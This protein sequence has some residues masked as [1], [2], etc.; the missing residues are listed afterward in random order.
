[1]RFKYKLTKLTKLTKSTKLKKLTL[2]LMLSTAIFTNFHNISF[3]QN[4]P[5]VSKNSSISNYKKIVEIDNIIAIVGNEVITQNELNKSYQQWEQNLVKNGIELPSKENLQKQLLERLILYKAQ[6]QKARELGISISEPEL[7]NSLN[8]I[9]A[10]NNMSLEEFRDFV[11]KNG[12]NFNSFQE[13]IRNEIIINKLRDAEIDSRINI[14]EAEIDNYLKHSKNNNQFLAN[15]SPVNEEIYN[16]QYLISHIIIRVPENA[17]PEVIE[18]YHNKAIDIQQKALQGQNFNRLAVAFSDAQ[19]ALSGGNLGW[20]NINELPNLYAEM[21][22]NLQ[23]N[24]ISPIVRSPAGFHIIKINQIKPINAKNG[25]KNKAKT[26]NKNK[27][28]NNK[29]KKVAKNTP[30]TQQTQQNQAQQAAADNPKVLQQTHVKH[31]LIRINEGVSEQK[32]RDTLQRVR[33]KILHGEDFGEQAKLY[34]QDASA[35]Q[36]G[37]LGWVNPGDTVPEFEKTM[38]NLPIGQVSEIIKTPFGV[39]LIWVLERRSK[40]I[41]AEQ[42]RSLARKILRDRHIEEAYQDWLREL[43]DATYVEIRSNNEDF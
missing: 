18:N 17:T 39:H 27:N 42:E 5:E 41:S 29:V 37:D 20:K 38:E 8:N 13:E 33:D 10:N 36:G 4:N 25:S 15:N 22:A 11:E 7:H 16:N 24:Q 19:D 34:S 35:P 32:A 14:S 6:L 1:M 31:I 43:R 26:K 12:T 2:S 21:V 9:A 28:K 23:E 3:A 30:Q 40:D